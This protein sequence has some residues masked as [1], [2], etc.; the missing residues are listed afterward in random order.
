M[1][2]KTTYL[3]L[4][5]KN[6]VMPG[7]SP[8]VDQLDNVRRLE[9]A[10]AAAI[11]MHSLFEEQITNQQLAEFAHTENPAESFSEATSYFPSMEDYALGPDRYLAQISKIKEMCDIPVIGSLNGVSIGGWTD[12]ARL[13]EQAGADALEL[14][15]YYVATDP[16]EPGT[17][18]Q[19]RTLDILQAVKGSVTIPVAMKLSPYFSSPGHFAKQLDAMGAA[20]VI[21]FN[22]FYQP[23]ID[24]EELEAAPRL[25]LSNSTELRLR[26]RWAAILHGHLKGDIC[27]GGGVHTVEDIIK[28]IMCGANVV[29]VVSSLL[30]YG[31]SHIGSLINGLRQWLEEHEYESVDQMRGSMSL[32]NCPDPTAFE[33]ANYLRVLQLWKV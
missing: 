31:P 9:D 17:A 11:V 2:L 12:H 23:D 7:A 19:Q 24:I 20:G 5:L 3:G 32:R 28:S 25:E 18:V 27:V 6:P 21:L 14:N 26:L 1:K 15:V 30:K 22:R 4:D 29:Q 10:G 8:L 13:I 33:R 16:D